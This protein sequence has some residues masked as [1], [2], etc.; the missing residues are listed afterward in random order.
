MNQQSEFERR[1]QAANIADR[2]YAVNND[3]REQRQAQER[4]PLQDTEAYQAG[5]AAAMRQRMEGYEGQ[6]IYPQPQRRRRPRRLWIVAAII[7]I[8]FALGG[9]FSFAHNANSGPA[10][11]YPTRT[12]T[13]GA[14][15]KVVVNAEAGTIQFHAGSSDTVTV[16]ATEKDGGPF[17]Q[18]HGANIQSTQDSNSNTITVDEQKSSG[19]INNANVI[20]DVT[21]PANSDIQTTLNLGD[22]SI[23]GVSGTM[24]VKDDTGKIDISNSTL[25]GTSSIRENIGDIT[26]QGAITSDGDYTFENNTGAINLTLPTN[27]IFALDSKTNIGKVS[28]QFDSNDGIATPDSHIHLHLKDDIGA[29]TINKQ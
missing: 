23:D 11:A 16:T 6:K 14:M 4:G 24:D 17:N 21:L 9:A 26:F 29:I 12:F 27:Q 28:N 8:L 3:P 1:E 18:S 15:P 7:L 10:T 2:S 5:Y 19:F 20:I 22:I 13:V 25:T